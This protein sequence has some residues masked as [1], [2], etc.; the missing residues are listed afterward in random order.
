[1]NYI[2][3]TLIASYF[4]CKREVWLMA[5]ELSPD[6]DNTFLEIGRITEE[7]FYKRNDKGFNVSNMKIDIVKKENNTTIIGE[8]KKSSSYEKPAIMQL[9]YY[10]MQ[11]RESGIKASGEIL[12]PKERKKISVKLTKNVEYKIKNAFKEIEKITVSEKAPEKRKITFCNHCAYK[13]F[14]WS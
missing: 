2:T 6:Q 5:H 3:G 13:E 7:S 12:I 1:M 4:V 14:C 10:L 9:S 8:V 11:L